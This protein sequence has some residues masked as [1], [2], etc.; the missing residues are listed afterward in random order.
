MNRASPG[1]PLRIAMVLDSWDDQANGGVVSTRRFAEWLRARGHVVTIVA[2]AAAG[3]HIEPLPSFEVP[4]FKRIMRRMKFTFAVPDRAVLA[5]VLATHDVVHVHFPFWLGVRTMRMARDA[6]VATIATFHVQGEHILYNVGIRA[7]WAVRQVYR[8]FLR[9]VYDHADRVLCPS[10]FTERELHRYGLRAPTV[11]ISNGVP[12]LFQPSPPGSGPGF[13]GRTVVLSV[14][15]LATEKRHDLLIEAV[16]RS[17]HAQSLQ[18]VILGAGPLRDALERQGRTLPH[19][20]VFGFLPT[21]ELVPYYGAAA[22]CVHASEVEVEGMA[23]LEALACGAPC[24]VADSPRSATPQFALDARYLF[25]SGS[26][27][28]LV[29]HLDALLDDPARLAADRQRAVALAG[30]FSFERSAERLEELY[31]EVRSEK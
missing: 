18:L 23:A 31:R 13:D 21:R 9:T 8:L 11:V 10:E 14:G 7:D 4:L 22:L 17:R 24:L 15:R 19:P 16:R 26:V 29:R 12:A 20:V 30:R 2:N 5:R 25:Q 6:G 28:S 27:E 1:G 3:P